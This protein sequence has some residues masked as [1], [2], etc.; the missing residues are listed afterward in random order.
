[1]DER[2]IPRDALISVSKAETSPIVAGVVASP[3]VEIL[4][5]IEDSLAQHLIDLD[6]SEVIFRYR[7][8]CR[9]PVNMSPLS[10]Q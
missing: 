10:V 7:R 3:E 4:E 1:M 2:V 5:M 6:L 9:C 8:V